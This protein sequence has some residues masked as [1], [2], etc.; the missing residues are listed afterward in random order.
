MKLLD[1]VTVLSMGVHEPSTYVS[2]LFFGASCYF[3]AHIG[4]MYKQHGTDRVKEVYLFEPGEEPVGSNRLC[5]Y[6]ERD[7]MR[8]V[9]G[10]VPDGAATHNH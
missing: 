10:R 7:W 5:Y 1:A 6:C 2:L 3:G 8:S 9:L 4:C